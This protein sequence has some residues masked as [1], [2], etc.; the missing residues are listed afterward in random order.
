MTNILYVD[1]RYESNELIELLDQTN[2]KD[3]E[4]SHSLKPMGRIAKKHL[5]K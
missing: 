5:T 1:D 4:E 3:D 2:I